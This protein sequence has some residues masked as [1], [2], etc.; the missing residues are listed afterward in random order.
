VECPT[1]DDRCSRCQKAGEPSVSSL[2]VLDNVRR[3]CPPERKLEWVK[4]ATSL[5]ATGKV[6]PEPTLRERKAASP[7]RPVVSGPRKPQ[8]PGVGTVIAKILKERYAATPKDGCGCGSKI[9]ELNRNGVDWCAANRDVIATDLV[10]AAAE[11]AGLHNFAPGW[12]KRWKMRGLVSEAIQTV[13]DWQ[14]QL[15]PANHST[16]SSQEKS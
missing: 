2:A 6:Q 10:R 16:E 13:R 3:V 14:P 15:E 7:G 5:A 12:A 8:R 9:A 11:V 1:S 4:A